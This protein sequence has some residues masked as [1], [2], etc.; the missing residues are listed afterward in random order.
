MKI[1]KIFTILLLLALSNVTLG[2]NSSI[3]TVNYN[4]YLNND[5]DLSRTNSMSLGY[6][7][8][9]EFSE[10]FFLNFGIVL[11]VAQ[12]ELNLNYY[13]YIYPIDPNTGLPYS[14]P[15]LMTTQGKSG[16]SLDIKFPFNIKTNLF[17]SKLFLLT[18]LS[19]SVDRCLSIHQN[20]YYDSEYDFIDYFHYTED[21]PGNFLLGFG[22]NLGVIYELTERIGMYAQMESTINNDFSFIYLSC[23]FD[24]KITNR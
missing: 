20:Y 7:Y 24:I 11:N 5:K 15:Y 2:Q 6:K 14:V 9:K 13:G 19:I 18:G 1:K 4:R 23:G 22:Y 17:N 21:L 10:S 16:Y 8:E 12:E 3:L